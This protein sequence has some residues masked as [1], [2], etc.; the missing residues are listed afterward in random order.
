[1]SVTVDTP[2]R[3]II[4]PSPSE[5]I[6]LAVTLC[7]CLVDGPNGMEA[8]LQVTK[9]GGWTSPSRDRKINGGDTG[10]LD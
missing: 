2:D 8:I 3:V 10:S 9:A 6:P 5:G 7:L 4:R 1:M